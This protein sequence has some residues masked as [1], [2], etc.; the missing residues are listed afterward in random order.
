[1]ITIIYRKLAQ[2]INYTDW[3]Y[4]Y[5]LSSWA[6]ICS[7]LGR[8]L[9][10]QTRCGRYEYSLSSWAV[11]CSR[12]GR[13]LHIQTRYVRYEYVLEYMGCDLHSLTR[14]FHRWTRIIQ[15]RNVR[16][17]LFLSS[18]TV[19]CS[20]FGRDKTNYLFCVY[21]SLT[22]A[23]H[24]YKHVVIKHSYILCVILYIIPRQTL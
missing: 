7:L 22:S 2:V 8:V 19:I 23:N 12:L 3:R 1:M 17:V 21:S 20:L 18:W 11:I 13:V 16:N 4:E 14:E 5:A 15:T 6:V 24:S 10:I 9:H